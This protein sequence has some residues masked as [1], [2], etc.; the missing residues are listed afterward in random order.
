[1]I[2]AARILEKTRAEGPGLR[3]CL[4]V[5]GC[6]IR[7]PGCYAAALQPL[8]GGF[9]V[10]EEELIRRIRDLAPELE[11]VTFLGGE[12]FL[13]AEAL[14]RVAAAA[15]AEGLSVL[16]FTGYVYEELLARDDAAVRA[17]LEQTDLLLDGPYRQEERDFSR[18]LVGSRN[19]SFRFLT[20]RYTPRDLLAWKNRVEI[21]IGKDGICRLN[22]MGD[23]PALE[24]QL[25]DQFQRR[26]EEYGILEF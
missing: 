24:R 16:C 1:M 8:D 13:Q 23:F 21:R 7:C 11:G 5:Q 4:W 20:G 14:A 6:T 25:Q 3:F 18:P 26:E 10:E 2:R 9:P 17:L 19:Q 22:G 12:P 15:R